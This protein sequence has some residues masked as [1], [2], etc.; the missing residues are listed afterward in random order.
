MFP[1]LE[2]FLQVLE[3]KGTQTTRWMLID[4]AGAKPP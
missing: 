1:Y 2:K 3:K 4:V